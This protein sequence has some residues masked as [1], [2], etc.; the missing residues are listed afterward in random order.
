MASNCPVPVFNNKN[1]VKH[2]L[3][4]PVIDEWLATT[5]QTLSD[6]FS[7]LILQSTS[8][9][10]TLGPRCLMALCGCQLC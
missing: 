6:W 2:K 10:T 7:S 3:V 1:L 5:K 8:S 9:V 4:I